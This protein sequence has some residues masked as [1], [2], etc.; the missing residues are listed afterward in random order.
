[1]PAGEAPEPV[2]QFVSSTWSPTN[3][4][5]DQDRTHARAQPPR[6]GIAPTKQI[7]PWLTE[8]VLETVGKKHSNRDTKQKAQKRLIRS[9]HL[10]PPTPGGEGRREDGTDEDDQDHRDGNCEYIEEGR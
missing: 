2:E 8:K 10:S 4:A 9:V 5:P 6:I 1:M 3:V 7:W